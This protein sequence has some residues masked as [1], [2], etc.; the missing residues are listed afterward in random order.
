MAPTLDVHFS[1]QCCGYK[2]STKKPRANTNSNQKRSRINTEAQVEAHI[3]IVEALNSEKN[4]T[5]LSQFH[6][7][8]K[9]LEGCKAKTKEG[10]RV[11]SKLQKNIV[12]YLL[13][14]LVLKLGGN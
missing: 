4:Q 8:F 12:S 9:S 7:L 5:T 3:E 6:R 2:L 10:K 1:N 13:T 11:R 14:N